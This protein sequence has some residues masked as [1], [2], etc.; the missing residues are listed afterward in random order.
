[1]AVHSTP[2]ATTVQ[3]AVCVVCSG[4]EGSLSRAHLEGSADGLGHGVAANQSVRDL[5]LGVPNVHDNRR[6]E[7][8][9]DGC[10]SLG[11]VQLAV[12]K[13]LVSAVRRDGE[14]VHGAADRDSVAWGEP[15]VKKAHTQSSYNQGRGIAWWFWA[16]RCVA[17]GPRRRE[18]SSRC[19]PKQR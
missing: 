9:A 14:P 19:W 6:L 3:R 1:M 13:T 11:S 17:D 5:D 18:R 2:L 4:E 8:V 16:W 7:V 12:D 10:H 15:V